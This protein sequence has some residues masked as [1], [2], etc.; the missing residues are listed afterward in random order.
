MAREVWIKRDECTSCNL[1][2]MTAPNTFR[3]NDDDNWAEVIEQG[4]DSEQDL[5]KSIDTCPVLIIH[6][7]D[8][9]PEPQSSVITDK[10]KQANS[11]N[12]V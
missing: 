12:P 11:N 5:Q 3:L 9:V 8:E 1:C 2:V 10:V 6:W 4:K 7:K